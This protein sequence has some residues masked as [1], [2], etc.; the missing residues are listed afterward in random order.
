LPNCPFPIV[1]YTPDGEEIRF[2]ASQSECLRAIARGY[3][4]KHGTRL[5]A[6]RAIVRVL[7]EVLDHPVKSLKYGSLEGQDQLAPSDLLPLKVQFENTRQD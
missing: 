4:R 3:N 6:D 7:T 5:P 1:I 2:T